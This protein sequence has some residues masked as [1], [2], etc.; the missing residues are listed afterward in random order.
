LRTLVEFTVKNQIQLREIALPAAR[1]LVLYTPT[2]SVA[3]DLMGQVLFFLDDLLNAERFI[4]R[5]IQAD[6]G[7]ALAHLHLAQVYLL[8]DDVEVAHQELLLAA[9]LAP[10]TPIAENAQR[11]LTSYFP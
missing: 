7:Y 4:R 1:Q 10:N 11:L 5:A 8:N 3:L 6:P 2:D 9:S